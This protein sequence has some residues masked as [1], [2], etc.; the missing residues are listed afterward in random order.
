MPGQTRI[1]IIGATGYVG[2]ELVRLLSVHESFQITALVSHH[3]AGK[4]FS[5]I[6]P[7]FTRVVDLP[8]LELDIDAIAQQCDIVVTA[9][10]HG[11]SAE[12]VPQLLDRGVRV[13]DHS[14]DFRYRDAAIYEGA[15]HIKHPCPEW[16]NKAVYG[17]PE[18]YRNAIRQAR[19]VA[20]PGCYPTCSLLAL[21]P[22]LKNHFIDPNSIIIDAVSG[23]SG[24][25]RKSGLDYAFCE[26]DNDFKPYGVVGH[27]HTSEIEQECGK[28]A[29][30]GPIPVTFTP[31][32]APFKRGMLATVYATLLP[33]QDPGNLEL[34]YRRMYEQE[35]FIRLMPPGSWPQVRYVAG[36]NFADV[37]VSYDAK[38]HRV[39]AFCALDNLGKGAAGQ[40]IQSLNLMA[41]IAE[42]E[43][44]CLVG[45]AV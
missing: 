19:L 29:E 1:G 17:L 45:Q 24:A 20:N 26:T 16:L 41:G 3:Y 36:T 39:K 44:L 7:A 22:L 10:P 6:Y 43:G 9:L 12:V 31:H 27:R 8:L 11:V 5:E 23:V 42:N 35:W 4:N 28:L 34:A 32:L 33:G 13:L 15:Y 2:M 37:A 14:G 25:G 30:T 38:T 40:A 18:I 21:M